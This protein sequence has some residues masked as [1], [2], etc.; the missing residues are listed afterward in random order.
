[1]R[2]YSI[3]KP[4]IWKRHYEIIN[5]SGREIGRI[6]WG[7]AFSTRAEAVGSFGKYYFK[8]NTW[9]SSISILDSREAEIGRIKMSAWNSKSTFF[10]KGQEFYFKKLHWA[11]SIY[12]WENVRGMKL[13]SFKPSFWGAQA[14]SVRVYDLY[15][16]EERFQD[17]VF[18]DLMMA[19]GHYMLLIKAQMQG[20]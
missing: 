3:S 2:V 9:G 5:E 17:L 19:L 18:Q 10:Y 6:S 13:M 12:L 16:E 1:M 15:Q 20:S 8:T 11:N 4:S 7:S 14:G